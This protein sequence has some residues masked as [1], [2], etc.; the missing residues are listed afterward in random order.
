MPI[1][2]PSWVEL[3]KL[4]PIVIVSPM[5]RKLCS[6]SCWSSLP[7]RDSTPPKGLKLNKLLLSRSGSDS[8]FSLS[9][10]KLFKPDSR[11]LLSVVVV[12]VVIV[13][14]IGCVVGIVVVVVVVVV[15]VC[16][17]SSLLVGP[18]CP[19]SFA[20]KLCTAWCMAA[21]ASFK[22]PSYKLLAV[23]LKLKLISVKLCWGGGWDFSKLGGLP[24]KSNVLKRGF[25]IQASS[26]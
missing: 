23:V 24:L 22:L 20:T 5:L 21:K 2:S 18:C 11:L 15:V 16:V 26:I 7:K 4:N 17:F 25:L 8:G 14:G 13:V 10:S 19:S 9:R 3:L 12:V 6:A 1:I